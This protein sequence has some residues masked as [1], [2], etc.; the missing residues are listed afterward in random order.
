[1]FTTLIRAFFGSVNKPFAIFILM[2]IGLSIYG[3]ALNIIEIAQA[4]GF[5]GLLVL[6]V[7]GIFVA[8]VGVVLG[9][10]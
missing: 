10:I 3:W 6:R 4:T 2:L 9:Y 8:P 1:M 5:S 7:V